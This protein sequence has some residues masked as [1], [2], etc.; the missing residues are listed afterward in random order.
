MVKYHMQE[1]QKDSRISGVPV[2]GVFLQDYRGDMEETFVPMRETLQS[3]IVGNGYGLIKV[4]WL[5]QDG[6]TYWSWARWVVTPPNGQIPGVVY[7]ESA[8]GSPM[9]WAYFTEIE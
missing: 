6:T 7:L 8:T 2:H 1:I 9:V 3:V 4:R 5:K